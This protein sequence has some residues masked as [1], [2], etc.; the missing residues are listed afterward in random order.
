MSD[1]FLEAA[2]AD[3]KNL[4]KEQ[5]DS[6]KSKEQLYKVFNETYE[7]DVA[8]Q[9]LL[10]IFTQDPEAK[11]FPSDEEI[12]ALVKEFREKAKPLLPLLKNLL[13]R[14]PNPA[15]S[16]M[17]YDFPERAKGRIMEYIRPEFQEGL[18]IYTALL[19]YALGDDE[20]LSFTASL[21]NAGYVPRLRAARRAYRRFM[22]F[23]NAETRT[24]QEF[25]KTEAYR[26]QVLEMKAG[27]RDHIDYPE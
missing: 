26:I 1:M 9:N 11:Y 10:P 2:V 7:N 4:S 14:F 21:K 3:Y 17:P 16:Y 12:E 23:K 27:E 20:S 5:W 24:R 15:T 8:K 13:K 22:E 25:E 6:L 19:I 18:G